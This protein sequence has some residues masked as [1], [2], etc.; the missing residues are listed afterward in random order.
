MT[1]IEIDLGSRKIQTRLNVA[2]RLVL[3][4]QDVQITYFHLRGS[5]PL[6]RPVAA[7]PLTKNMTYCP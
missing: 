5:Y 2:L 1:V 6:E 7:L 3:A 4:G